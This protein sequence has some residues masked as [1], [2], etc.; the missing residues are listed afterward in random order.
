MIVKFQ[1]SGKESFVPWLG[2]NILLSLFLD[3]PSQILLSLFPFFTPNLGK[4]RLEG[5]MPS[6]ISE[7]GKTLVC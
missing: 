2:S 5:Y 3:W 6:F 4:T 1:E 7:S